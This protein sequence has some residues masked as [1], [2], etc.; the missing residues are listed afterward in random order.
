MLNLIRAYGFGTHVLSDDEIRRRAPSVFSDH[1]YEGTSGRYAVVPTISVVNALREEGWLPTLAGESRARVANRKGFT[2]HLVRLRR[3]QDL[4]QHAVVGETVPEIVLLNSHDGTSSYQLHAG[5]FRYVC[6][7]G[8][9]VS[10]SAIEKQR[11][12]HTGDVVDRVIEGT[13]KI[14]DMMPE[15]LDRIDQMGQIEMDRDE[16]RVFGQAAI[17]L[18]WDEDEEG[19][20]PV[21]PEQVTY[22][23]RSADSGH[24]LWSVLN[25]AQENIIR[26]GVIAVRRDKYG[27]PKRSRTRAVKSVQENVRLNKA[28]WFLAE[29]FAHLKGR[30]VA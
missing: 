14:I 30:Q 18:K 4:E 9:I 7:N 17:A 26:G 6:T 11:F 8:M 23:R 28:L 27:S 24:N 25:R 29:E 22:A 12:R 10:D 2:K 13:Y 5:L 15:T 16:T 1:A 20:F 3:T 21:T 19:N